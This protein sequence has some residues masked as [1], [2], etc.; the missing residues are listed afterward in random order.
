MRWWIAST[1]EEYVAVWIP[2]TSSLTFHHPIDFLRRRRVPFLFWNIRIFWNLFRHDDSEIAIPPPPDG[3][4]CHADD[5]HAEDSLS[6]L[7]LQERR[8]NIQQSIGYP[9]PKFVSPHGF[10]NRIG[11][12]GTQES[13]LHLIMKSILEAGDALEHRE[14]SLNHDNCGRMNRISISGCA[15]RLLLPPSSSVYGFPCA[16]AVSQRMKAS[17]ALSRRSRNQKG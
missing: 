13:R 12:A 7:P 9:L 6:M 15:G 17:I 14:V 5:G 11:N 8:N 16:P 2:I 1:D 4:N 3:E 10:S